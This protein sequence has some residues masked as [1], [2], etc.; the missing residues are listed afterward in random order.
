[1]DKE[2]IKYKNEIQ[3]QLTLSEAQLTSRKLDVKDLKEQLAESEK[4]IQYLQQQLSQKVFELQ[5]SDHALAENENEFLNQDE[6]FNELIDV[7]MS[8]N[9]LNPKQDI[10][11]LKSKFS[12]KKRTI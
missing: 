4:K 12:I 7:L 9:S 2:T 3:S 11:L 8:S 6:L 10:E 5:A 1:M